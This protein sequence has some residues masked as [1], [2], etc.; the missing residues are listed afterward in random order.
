MNITIDGQQIEVTT[1]DKNIVDVA[2]RM[3]IGIPAACYRSKQSKGCCH[4]CVV[5]IDGEQKFACS[6]TPEDGME[7]VFDRKDLK[8]LRKERL[9]EY[10]TGIDSGN[11]CQCKSSGPNDCCG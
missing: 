9:L 4:A 8:E 2:D 11:P 7:V 10:Q 5:E 1:D 6:T 3:K